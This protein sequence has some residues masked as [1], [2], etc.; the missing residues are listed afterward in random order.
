MPSRLLAFATLVALSSVPAFAAEAFPWTGTEKLSTDKGETLSWT[1]EHKD[2]EVVITGTH[3]KWA[4][5]HRARP[6][7]TPL[8]TTRR[9]G[10]TSSKV[11]FA[12]D[13]ARYEHTGKDGKTVVTQVAVR[14]L[15]DSDTLDARLAG[16]NWAEGR[17]VKFSAIDTDSDDAT[18]YPLV[19][20]Y[21]GLEKCAAGPCH[22]VRVSLD[23]LRRYFA[24]TWDFRYGTSAAAPY[25]QNDSDGNTFTAR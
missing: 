17:K 15:W 22:H 12:A 25:L 1:V 6:D 18:V 16:I 23:D 9:S 21:V 8:T 4:V 10:K 2:G 19:A 7:G 5:E 20:E 13:G 14:G 11:T 3:P 24:P